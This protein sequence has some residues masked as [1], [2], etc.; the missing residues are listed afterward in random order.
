MHIFYCIFIVFIGSAFGAAEPAPVAKNGAVAQDGSA[1]QTWGYVTV[2]P[3]AHMFWWLYYTTASEHYE[4]RPL[5]L[6]LQGG[7]GASGTGFGNFAEIGPLDINKEPRNSSW[8]HRV[9]VLFVDNPVGSGFSYVE[10]DDLFVKNNS[11]ISKDLVTLLKEFSLRLPEFQTTPFYIFSES[12]GGKMAVGLARQLQKEITSKGIKLAFKG[13]ALGDS[14]ISPVDSVNSWSSY[15]FDLGE[16]A[17]RLAGKQVA[18]AVAAGNMSQ[19]TE[20]WSEAEN[21]VDTESAGVNFYNILNPVKSSSLQTKST[22]HLEFLF[23][24][25]VQNQKWRDGE[26]DVL[27]KLMNG[28]IREKLRVVP[29]NVTWG[30]QSDKAHFNGYIICNGLEINV[31]V[32]PIVPADNPEASIEMLK[33]ITKYDQ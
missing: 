8:V 3:G 26:D 11:E 7:P 30:G 23:K 16:S 33:F 15:L 17:V 32:R 12:Y 5:V 20:L 13:I 6:W 31:G 21:V 10:K 28:E 25:H 4:T 14:W 18:L 24:R 29:A 19:A 1:R 27:S 22:N 9:N 2:R